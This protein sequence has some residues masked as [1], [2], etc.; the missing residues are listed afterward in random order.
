MNSGEGIINDSQEVYEIIYPTNPKKYIGGIRQ[1]KHRGEYTN[2]WVCRIRLNYGKHSNNTTHH[3]FEQAFEYLKEYNIKHSTPIRNIIHKY[4]DRIE[5]ECI[6]NNETIFGIFDIE[7]IDTI[8]EYN[9]WGHQYRKGYK[10]LKTKIN[11]KIRFFCHVLLGFNYDKTN[12][13]TIDHIDRNPLNN[14]RENLRIANNT[15][16]TNNQ[17]RVLNCKGIIHTK[18][19]RRWEAH[20]GDGKN[21]KSKSYSYDGETGRTSSYALALAYITRKNWE[22]ERDERIDTL[23]QQLNS[24][25]IKS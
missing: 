7:D 8:Q 15:I 12:N 1:V 2:S 17:D 3:S 21:K 9:I 24:I 14:R 18:D 10:C 23:S 5:V 4:K 6:C 20:I 13:L 22:E 16:Q 25:S 19:R 11:G